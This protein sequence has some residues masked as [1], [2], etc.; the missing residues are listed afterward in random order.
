MFTAFLCSAG[1]SLLPT[2]ASGREPDKSSS[3]HHTL[4]PSAN[5]SVELVASIFRVENKPRRTS[6]NADVK[7][8]PL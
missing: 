1:N 7:Q 6:V 2:I 5:V 8:P 4:F 3:H